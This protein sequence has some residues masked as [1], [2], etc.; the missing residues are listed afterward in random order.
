MRITKKQIQLIQTTWAKIMLNSKFNAEFFYD[1]LFELNPG[2]Q[3]MFKKDQEEQERILMSMITMIVNSLHQSDDM[4]PFFLTLGNRHKKYGVKKSNYNTFWTALLFM[5]KAGLRE[6]F[7]K[8]TEEAWKAV[9]K[10][11]ASQMT[12]VL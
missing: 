11:M 7:T 2:L 4:A 12:K 10:L 8:E 6:H 3:S 5:L 1:L 9:Y